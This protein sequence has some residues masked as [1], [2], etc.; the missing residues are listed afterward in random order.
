MQGRVSGVPGREETG[1]E[2]P[3]EG[4]AEEGASA[5]SGE[6]TDERGLAESRNAAAVPI[7]TIRVT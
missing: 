3:I 5:A 4:E 1:R 2:K 7:R 6:A